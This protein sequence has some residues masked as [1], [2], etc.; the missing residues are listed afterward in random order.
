MVLS[1]LA[2]QS[3]VGRVHMS[4]S[5]LCPSCGG[6]NL[7]PIVY[8][9]LVGDEL[10]EGAVAGGCEVSDDSPRWYCLDCRAPVGGQRDEE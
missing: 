1:T 4:R 3:E 7:R 5:Q 2:R 10:P 6:T 9:L 8:G